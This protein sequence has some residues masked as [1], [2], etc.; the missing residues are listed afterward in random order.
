MAHKP[1]RWTLHRGYKEKLQQWRS[2]LSRGSVKPGA[3]LAYV[4]QG[5]DPAKMTSPALFEALTQTREPTRYAES[6]V[7]ADDSDWTF[8]EL[9]LLG[10]A[11]FAVPVTIYDNGRHWEPQVHEQP[12]KGNLLF[13]SG[14]L[15]RNDYGNPVP[16]RS[17]CV[18]HGEL[19]PDAFHKLIIR[20][21]RPLLAF[22][23]EQAGQ[24]GKRSVVTVPGVGCGQ[25]AGGILGIAEELKNAI[26][27]LLESEPDRF[28]NIS[29]IRLDTHATLT[30]TAETIHGIEFRVRP[31]IKGNDGTP[32]LA[33]LE[34]LEENPGEFTD[35]ILSSVVAWDPV[36]WPGNDFYAG[37]R[38]T[39]DG[40]KAAATNVIERITG[41]AGIYSE[42]D[43]SFVPKD[44][45]DDTWETIIRKQGLSLYTEGLCIV[46][47]KTKETL[48]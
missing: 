37:N 6:E 39:D 8:E 2:E 38:T 9:A 47:K 14:A 29:C 45:P 20:R 48:H 22:A 46:E 12:F 40:V 11:G 21:L 26:R 41:I 31:L 15:L 7:K 43:H 33:D 17:E 36:S 13:M 34:R 30:N 42:K 19:V 1:Y 5:K 28:N 44:Y 4:L 16:D 32:Q 23:N 25:F 35:H 3:R 10:D 24:H 27:V 18:K